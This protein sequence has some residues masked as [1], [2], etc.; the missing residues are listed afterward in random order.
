MKLTNDE[1]PDTPYGETVD[2]VGCSASQKDDD[3]DGVSNLLDKCPDTPANTPV[4]SEGCVSEKAD[5]TA[6][7][8]PTEH[9]Q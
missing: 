1:C 6:I 9:L 8:I 7:I 3:E 4:D 5:P 2:E